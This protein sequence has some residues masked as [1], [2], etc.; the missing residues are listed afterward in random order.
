MCCFVFKQQG[1]ADT[2]IHTSQGGLTTD[3]IITNF[4]VVTFH[5]DT[6]VT[7]SPTS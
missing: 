4:N 2:A 3:L 6:G 5:A 7:T 1:E